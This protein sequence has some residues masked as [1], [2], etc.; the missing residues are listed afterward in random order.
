VK[1]GSCRS[2]QPSPEPWPLPPFRDGITH[3]RTQRKPLCATYQRRFHLGPELPHLPV[4]P[5][6]RPECLFP[7]QFICK[8]GIPLLLLGMAMTAVGYD[9]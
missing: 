1:S 5:P 3:R 8:P 2:T 7:A 9:P 6:R 4:I